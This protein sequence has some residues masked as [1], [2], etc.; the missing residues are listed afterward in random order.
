MDNNKLLLDKAK[1]ELAKIAER[2]KICNKKYYEKKKSQDRQKNKDKYCDHCKKK[3]RKNYGDD[4]KILHKKCKKFIKE[5][6]KYKQ[7]EE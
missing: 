1:A 7:Q 5:L 2:R 6:A 3:I 4:G